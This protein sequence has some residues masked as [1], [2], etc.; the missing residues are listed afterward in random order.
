MAFNLEM[1]RIVVVWVDCE[2]CFKG[3]IGSDSPGS[4]DEVIHVIDCWRDV[5]L[6]AIM[7]L[8][9]V[10]GCF[11]CL[12]NQNEWVARQSFYHCVQ[13]PMSWEE[14]HRSW[15]SHKSGISV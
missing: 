10:L 11:D 5:F 9:K 6:V 12:W 15:V 8:A 2:L 14:R 4:K 13:K 7:F 3:T 1:F